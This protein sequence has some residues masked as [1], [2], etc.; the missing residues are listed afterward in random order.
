MQ[1]LKD[2]QKN[3]IYLCVNMLVI[4]SLGLILCMSIKRKNYQN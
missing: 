1:Y 3:K 2:N 4:S